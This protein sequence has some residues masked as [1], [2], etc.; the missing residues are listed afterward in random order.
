MAKSGIGRHLTSCQQRKDLIAKSEKT[1]AGTEPL[2]HIRLE[3]LRGKHY[4]LDIEMRGSATLADL[5]G[6]LRDI[7]LECCGHLSAFMIGGWRGE[8]IGEDEMKIKVGQFLRVGL[9]LLHIYDFGTSSETLV[10]VQG[11]REGKPL[12]KYPVVLMARNLPPEFHCQECD[13][14]ATWFCQECLFEDGTSGFLCDQHV[15][16][17][18]HE[19]YGEPISVVNSPRLGLCGYTGLAEPPY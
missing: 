10:K 18:P 7:W 8:E 14:V 9:E 19:D 15:K 12:T 13:R 2:Y 11:V 6:Y 1:K 4:W 5:D 16:K 17:H 3:A